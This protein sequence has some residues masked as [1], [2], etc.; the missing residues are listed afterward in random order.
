MKSYLLGILTISAMS[1]GAAANVAAQRT[2]YG[3][4]TNGMFGYR[5]IGGAP[6]GVATQSMFGYRYIGPSLNSLMIGGM[7]GTGT[8]FSSRLTVPYTTALVPPINTV[9][10]TPETAMLDVNNMEAPPVIPEAAQLPYPGPNPTTGTEGMTPVPQ[11]AAPAAQAMTPAVPQGMAPMPQAPAAGLTGMAAPAVPSI[12]FP[13]GWNFARPASAA[14]LTAFSRSVELSNRMTQ[15]ARSRGMLAGPGIE[16]LMR[17]DVTV[18]Q[19]KVH[20]SA[21]AATLANVLSLE[22]Q[23]RRIDNRLATEDNTANSANSST[24]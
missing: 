15:L 21:E 13:L 16:V 19:G 4:G 2:Y 8:T 18:L 24:R 5:V 12:P 9:P 14:P 20:T 11:G 6:I 17:G 10:L 7:N 22:P 1:F 3:T 23:V